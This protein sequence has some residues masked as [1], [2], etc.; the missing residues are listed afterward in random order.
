M[1]RKSQLKNCLRLSY[2]KFFKR[3]FLAN[4]WCSTICG[5]VGLGCTKS[6]LKKSKSQSA[7]IRALCSV[8]RLSFC[9]DSLQWWTFTWRCKIKETLSSQD[10]YGQ[11][12]ITATEKKLNQQQDM[13]KIWLWMCANVKNKT[14]MVMLLLRKVF[15][16][17]TREALP[18]IPRTSAQTSM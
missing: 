15:A 3:L 11:C 7:S 14:G 13:M 18:S 12:F 9:P 1:K 2:G 5:Q 8:S 10:A 16:Q 4:V 6:L 17:S